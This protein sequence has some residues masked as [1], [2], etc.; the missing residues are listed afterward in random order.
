MVDKAGIENATHLL[1]EHRRLVQAL[2]HFAN[3][4]RIMAMTVAGRSRRFG[5]GN[6]MPSISVSTE[7]IDYPPQMVEAIKT[8][9]QAR[10]Q[11]ILD[12]LAGMGVTGIEEPPK[13]NV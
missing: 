6:L 11:R 5:R 2:D 3:G 13:Q 9:L 8:A 12:E 4:G 1:T 10:R 7:D